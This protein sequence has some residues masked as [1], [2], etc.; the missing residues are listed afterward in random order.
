MA[1]IFDTDSLNKHLNKLRF[2]SQPKAPEPIDPVKTAAAQS[3]INKETAVSQAFLNNVNETN[4]FGSRTFDAFKDPTSGEQRFSATTALNPQ[5]QAAFDAEQAVTRGTNE[6][7][8]GQIGRIG[9]AVADPFTFDGLPNAPVA[10]LEGRQR[11]EDA[12]FGR[13]SGRL[14]DRFGREEDA[15]TARLATQGITSGSEASNDALTQFGETKNDAFENASLQAILAGGQE[16]NRQF[17]LDATAR[18]RAIQEQS[19]L[20]NIPLNEVGALLGTGSV[21]IPQFGQPAQ[22]GIGGTDFIGAVGLQQQ[23]LNNAFNAKSASANAFNSGLFSL[24]GA[25]LGGLGKAFAGPSTVIN[26]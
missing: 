15:L 6:L 12:L 19:F 7:A 8:A 10:G 26:R 20:R 9:D 21:G 1:M 22:T 13:L 25:A 24:G 14:T 16:Q 4:P 5:G 23:A 18:D 2:K 11:V 3:S 17:G